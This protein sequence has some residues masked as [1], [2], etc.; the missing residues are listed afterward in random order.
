MKVN[1]ENYDDTL[2]FAVCAWV[3][4][5]Y[6]T[7]FGTIYQKPKGKTNSRDTTKLTLVTGL[8][9]LDF[10]ILPEETNLYY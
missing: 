4:N 10:D 8:F 2:N 6:K 9:F 5:K 7:K 1:K 3:K